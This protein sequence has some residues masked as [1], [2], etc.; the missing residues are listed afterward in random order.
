MHYKV[1]KREPCNYVFIVTSL[2]GIRFAR[3]FQAVSSSSFLQFWKA[4][5]WLSHGE[6]VPNKIR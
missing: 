6:L 1:L 2:N 4:I 5:I 3:N